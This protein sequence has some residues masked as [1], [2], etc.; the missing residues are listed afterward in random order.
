M[1][2]KLL[3]G[4]W[5]NAAQNGLLHVIIDLDNHNFPGCTTDT[6]DYAAICGHID[7]VQFLCNNRQERCSTKAMNG[8]SAYGHINVVKFLYTFLLDYCNIEEAI[9]I[10]NLNCHKNIVEF[11][12]K[13]NKNNKRKTETTKP[14]RK[15]IKIN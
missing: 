14:I 5:N 3:K 7:I 2:D 1:Q 10:A 11:L 13:Q 9:A 12:E 8:A 4:F 6:M 15:K